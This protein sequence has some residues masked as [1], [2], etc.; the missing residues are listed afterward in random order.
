MGF[1]ILEFLDWPEREILLAR[2]ITHHNTLE[3]LSPLL[4]LLIMLNY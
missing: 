2:Q 4:N 3:I 1:L